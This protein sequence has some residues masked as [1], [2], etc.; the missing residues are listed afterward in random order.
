MCKIDYA[1][2]KM[3]SFG[4]FVTSHQEALGLSQFVGGAFQHYHR[5]TGFVCFKRRCLFPADQLVHVTCA[6]RQV[7]APRN[8]MV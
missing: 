1:H 4:F 2:F 3:R 8:R 6:R 5:L 7:D